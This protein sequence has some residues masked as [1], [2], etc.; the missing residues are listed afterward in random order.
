[1]TT[2]EEEFWEILSNSGY[3]ETDEYARIVHIETKCDPICVVA[4]I[5]TKTNK[6][7]W[8]SRSAANE[9]GLDAF[10]AERVRR[11]AIDFGE[12]LIW[13]HEICKISEERL[14]S[15]KRKVWNLIQISL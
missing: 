8:N 9:I 15:I 3:Y 5:K 11:E 10:F 14:M 12:P 4:N 1:M 13:T 2:T 6:Y 7:K